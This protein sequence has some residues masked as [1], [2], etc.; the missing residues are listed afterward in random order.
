MTNKVQMS[1][2]D[3]PNKCVDG[4]IYNPYKKVKTVCKYCFDKRKEL[5]KGEPLDEKTGA[6]LAEILHLPESFVGYSYDI[7]TIVPQFVKKQLVSESLQNVQDKLD[8]LM[9]SISAG[10]TPD[11]SYMIN[12]GRKAYEQN[13]I[14]PLLQRAYMIGLTVAPFLTDMDVRWLKLASTGDCGSEVQSE[15]AKLGIT[16]A[17]LLNT[18]ICVVDILAGA[19]HQNITTVKGLIQA[20]ALRDKSTIVFT[21]EWGI[22]IKA[23][24]SEDSDFTKNLCELVSVEYAVNDTPRPAPTPRDTQS[25]RQS[26]EIPSMSS[27]DLNKLLGGL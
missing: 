9:K 18:D 5:V 25:K 2:P 12:L 1:F 27:A 20:R 17:E 7:S 3:C 23:L 26:T 4:Y 19:E 11:H 10:G 8:S 13:Y 21:N 22:A 24:C 6:T 16:Y 15:V 14:S